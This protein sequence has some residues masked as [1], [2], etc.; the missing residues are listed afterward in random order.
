MA[1]RLLKGFGL[2]I[3][4]LGMAFGLLI[5]LIVI[6][7]CADVA[8]RMVGSGSL[9]WVTELTEYLL[10]AGTFLAAPWVLRQGAHVRVDMLL[11]SVPKRVAVRIEQ[12]LDVAGLAIACVLAWHGVVAVHDAFRDNMVQFKT[13]N[14][15]EWLLL[16]VVPLSAVLLAVEFMLRAARVEGVVKDGYDPSERPGL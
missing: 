6:S 2:V 8:M 1:A 11:I 14:M 15:P 9:P 5:G 12:A 16:A 4:S 13:W 7:I 10:Y 3:D